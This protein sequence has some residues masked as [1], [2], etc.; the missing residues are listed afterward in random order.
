M[1]K[2]IDDISIEFQTSNCKDCYFAEL[3]K[4][5]TG[6]PCCTYPGRLETTHIY[7]TQCL[8][9]RQGKPRA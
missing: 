9:K 6:K 2:L 7:P 8:S 1:S 4:V 5:G 3:K